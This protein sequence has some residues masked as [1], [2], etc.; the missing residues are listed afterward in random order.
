MCRPMK[1]HWRH[2]EN[3]IKPSSQPK[4]YLDRFSHFCAAHNRASIPILYNGPPLPVKIAPSHG[5]ILT[6][7]LIHDSLGP[8]EPITQMAS[9]SVQPFLQDSLL[10]QTDRQTDQATQSVT[11]GGIYVLHSTAMRSN[12][13]KQN[14]WFKNMDTVFS[15]VCMVSRLGTTVIQYTRLTDDVYVL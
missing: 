6:S 2:L 8:S 14:M 10:W 3:M 4:Q 9:R 15:H 12:K 5:A 1:A 7:Y 13:M 11:I